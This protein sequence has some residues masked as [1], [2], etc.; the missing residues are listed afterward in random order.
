MSNFPRNFIGRSQSTEKYVIIVK[1]RI[2]GRR[3]KVVT[4]DNQS[5]VFQKNTASGEGGEGFF[6]AAKIFLNLHIKKWMMK[7]DLPTFVVPCKNWS[8][9]EV[10]GISAYFFFSFFS[11]FFC[12]LVKSFWDGQSKLKNWCYVPDDF[13]M[14]RTPPPPLSFFKLNSNIM[15]P[16]WSNYINNLF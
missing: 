9:I 6:G 8:E 2:I 7:L 11:A 12:P 10:I 16:L 5:F 13:T 1:V 3:V 14:H 15:C 4:N